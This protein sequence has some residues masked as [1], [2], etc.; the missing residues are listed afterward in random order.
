MKKK[1]HIYADQRTRKRVGYRIRQ[2]RLRVNLTLPQAASHLGINKGNLSR[3]ENGVI[4]LPARWVLPIAKLFGVRP[5]SIAE[6]YFGEK[7]CLTGKM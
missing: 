2:L 7:G 5:I 1:I 3:I 6:L 4:L